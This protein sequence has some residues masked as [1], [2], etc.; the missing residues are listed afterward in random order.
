MITKDATITIDQLTPGRFETEILPMPANWYLT[1]VC[2]LLSAHPKA[3]KNMLANRNCTLLLFIWLSYGAFCARKLPEN[4]KNLPDKVWNALRSH[5]WIEVYSSGDLDNVFTKTYD[6]NLTMSGHCLYR[7]VG[8]Y[9]KLSQNFRCFLN[10]M[11]SRL[12]KENRT[13]FQNI[14]PIS[15]A[16][17]LFARN[18][19][20][21]FSMNEYLPTLNRLNTCFDISS[22]MSGLFSRIS[23]SASVRE[24]LNEFKSQKDPSKFPI[25]W[26]RLAGHPDFGNIMTELS[27]SIKTWFDV[28]QITKSGPGSY[29][30]KQK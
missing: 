5:Q 27:R 10:N 16:S 13:E 25:L 24:M 19:D 15:N 11:Y 21:N 28:H 18:Y 12:N 26:E 2:D 3:L 20:A 29:L 22:L 17:E 7:T 6:M 9:N 1:Q 30:Q 23:T 8:D 4:L 14:L